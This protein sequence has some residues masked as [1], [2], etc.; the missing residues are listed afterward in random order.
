MIKEIKYAGY[1]AQPADYSSPDGDIALSMN[2]IPEN[3]ALLPILPPSEVLSLSEG[4]SVVYIHKGS[5]Y[6]NYIIKTTTNSQTTLTLRNSSVPILTLQNSETIVDIQAIG[7]ILVVSTSLHL[8]YIYYKN[9]AYTLLDTELPKVNMQFSLFGELVS[10]EHTTKLTFSDFASAEGSWSLY[11]KGSFNADLSLSSPGGT[12]NATKAT[13][14]VINFAKDLEANTEYRFKATGA[15]FTSVYLYGK[16]KDATQYEKITPIGSKTV[17]IKLKDTYTSFK[18]DVFNANGGI[19]SYHATGEIK[20]SSGFETNVTGKVITYNQE[21]YNAVAGAINKFVAERAIQKNKFIYPFFIRYALRLY[22]GSHARISEPIMMIPNSNY[23]PFINFTAGSNTLT[24]YSFISELRYHI[25]EQIDEKWRDIV[26]GV[27]IYASAQIYPY[28]QGDN[29]DANENHFSYAILNNTGLDQITG[30]NYGYCS[31]MNPNNGIQWGYGQHDLCYIANSLL[32]FA[33]TTKQADWR[34]IKL[35]PADDQL[36]KIK[37]ASQFFLIHSFDFDDIKETLQYDEVDDTFYADGFR[38][39]KL[40]SGTLSSLVARQT[41]EDDSLSNC[42]FYNAHLTT[43]NQRLH[44]FDYSMHLPA[45]TMPH[46]QNGYI[47]RKDNDSYGSLQNIQ[48]F[49]RTSQ[50]EKVVEANGSELCF[51][52]ATP[53][54][55]YP[56]NGAYKAILVF[57]K[58]TESKLNIVTLNLKQHDAL[59]GAYWIADTINDTMVPES[60]TDSYTPSAVNDTAYYPNAILQSNAAM[61]FLFSSRLMVSLGVGRVKALS[62]A[63]K[64]LSQGQFGQF[65][66]YAFTS[67]GIWALEVSSTGTYAAKQPIT[68]DVCINYQGI[69]QLDSAVLFPTERGIML[70]SGSQTECISDSINTDTPFS[71]PSLPGSKTLLSFFNTKVAT[72]IKTLN[73]LQSFQDFLATC[74]M[75]YDYT[76]QRVIVYNSSYEYAYVYSLE[77]KQWGMIQSNFVSNINS[78]PHAMVMDSKNRLL[79]FS[80]YA[81]TEIGVLLVS[82]PLKLDAPDIHKTIDTIIQRG[83]FQHGHIGQVLWASNDLYSWHLVWDSVD[84]YLRGFRGS[85]YKYFRIGIVGKLQNDESLYGASIQFQL[86]LVNQPR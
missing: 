57:K 81:T 4:Q 64:A 50:G 34:I 69:T 80:K 27:D 3:G 74:R 78:Y 22:D 66:L 61:P 68:R 20:I 29:F 56:H 30:S 65:P 51:T 82:R 26:S 42:T 5:D 36:E 41:L 45:P 85:P 18:L 19:T 77:S 63:A 25:D 14:I 67:E 1:T 21:N 58:Q 52:S 47:K 37:K 11:A 38:P 6:V 72:T 12:N 84:E 73:L 13:G 2:L 54:F 16:K 79:D 59:N 33:D 53:W 60:Q 15:G 35:A 83:M 32:G 49:I 17:T 7:N 28:N 46:L 9:S 44:L 31:L 24:L 23:A 8:Y 76:H 70:I 39:L 75:I 40:E 71:F 43:Y 62:S 86:R 10:C 48:V 55:Y